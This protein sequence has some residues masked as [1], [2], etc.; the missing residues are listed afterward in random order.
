MSSSDASGDEPARREWPWPIL[1]L[2]LVAAGLLALWLFS[3]TQ[4]GTP[5]IAR[6]ERLSG[7]AT[8]DGRMPWSDSARL[9]STLPIESGATI[10]TLANGSVLLA[11]TDTLRVRLAPDTVAHFEAA[12]SI[13]LES[14]KLYVDAV[15]GGESELRV[16]TSHG[17][18]T[19]A[20]TQYEALSRRQIFELAV[21]EGQ[22]E[23]E[24]AG[25]TTAVVAA[26]Q[27]LV[28][29]AAGNEQRRVVT[30]T[31]ARW[32]WLAATPTPISIEGMELTEFLSWY[33]R[34]TGRDVQFAD[35]SV[36]QASREIRLHGSIESMTPDDA[37]STVMAS[38]GLIA[39]FDA[40]SAQLRRVEILPLF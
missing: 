5:S 34:E 12:E 39:E 11:F 14:G 32:S 35:A 6:I 29:D 37:L 31:D 38:S 28:I 33:E 2:S 3:R 20:G 9:V 7:D 1:A 22:V 27:A 13:V 25:K 10:R 4:S 17:E 23:L 24:R 40:G 21:R 36:E 19:H 15:P 26:G 30:P 18:L 8:I 16:Q